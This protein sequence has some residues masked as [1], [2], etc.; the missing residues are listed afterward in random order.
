[1]KEEQER[2][3]K[4]QKDRKKLFSSSFQAKT[5]S[6]RK[7][8]SFIFLVFLRAASTVVVLNLAKRLSAPCHEIPLRGCAPCELFAR[9]Y[10]H[11]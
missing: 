10:E 8:L 9:A 5:F 7:Y 6:Q 11:V 1:V 4:R 2:E 3:K